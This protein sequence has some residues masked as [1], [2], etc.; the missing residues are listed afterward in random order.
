MST[1]SRFILLNNTS[2]Q[3][4]I[5]NANNMLKCQLEKIKKDKL[6]AFNR[7]K[8]E[9]P[10]LNKADFN[11][12]VT[13]PD[14][15]K[16]HAIFTESSFKP[17]VNMAFQYYKISANPLPTFGNSVVYDINTY[18]T[19]ISDMVLN[20][21]FSKLSSVSS[22]DKCKYAEF[23]GHRALK[24][25]EIFLNNTLFDT[26]Y[27][28]HY[29]KYY[30]FEVPADKKI[31]W[32]RSV[33]Q[34]IPYQG[35]LV[36]DP[37][38]DE[39][40]EIRE[41]TSGAQTLKNVQD[42]LEMWI[43]IFL[44]FQNKTKAI[45]THIFNKERGLANMQVKI[46]FEDA[47]NLMGGVDY[48][49]G[50]NINYSS[51]SRADLYTKHIDVDDSIK[52]IIEQRTQFMLVR[53]N[54]IQ[55]QLLNKPN[56]IIKLTELRYAIEYFTISIAPSSNLTSL[57]DWTKRYVLT[58]NSIT[59]PIITN[60]PLPNTLTSQVITYNTPSDDIDSLTVTLNATDLFSKFNNKFF[61]SYVPQSSSEM[62]APEDQGWMIVSFSLDP[63]SYQHSTY[64][65]ASNNREL[66]ISYESSYI[67]S[68][69]TATLFILGTSI[70]ILIVTPNSA[71][72]QFFG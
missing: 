16:T 15:M 13:I 36:Q 35:R 12:N 71:K 21:K 33:G 39:I 68:S 19:F 45:P 6:D 31:G 34:E 26:Y 65:N 9:N 38:V 42:E 50:G 18:G 29:N 20:L 48:G 8:K 4:T 70:N 17:H 2:T 1:G 53:S 51:I 24:K 3:D 25:V 37:T 67:N 59:V 5:L 43:P 27:S 22:L 23:V 57:D 52:H 60:N 58:P 62:N 56:D 69:N 63:L 61:S 49:G 30:Q 47:N 11:L 41:F 40:Q 64:F 14:I 46:Y 55:T 72:L 44:P 32:M 7:L 66:F 28:E 54:Q 10:N